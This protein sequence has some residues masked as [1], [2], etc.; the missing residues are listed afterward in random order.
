MSW[1][2]AT[3]Q[4][5]RDLMHPDA[6]YRDLDEEIAFHLELETRRQ[7]DAGCDPAVARARALARFGNPQLIS[8]AARSERGTQPLEGS[9]QDLRWAARSL[10]KSPGFTLLALFTLM[11]GI[12]ATTA[13]FAV[14]DTVL[15][16]PLPY[17]AA[18]RLVV[19]QEQAADHSTLYP[20]YPNFDD[21]RTQLRSFEHVA[22]VK[23]DVFR[24][25]TANGDVVRATALGVSRDFFETLGVQPAAGRVFTP[26]E[27]HIGGPRVLMVSYEFWQKYMGGAP[28]LGAIRLGGDSYQVVGVAPLGFQFMR[29]Y[30][31]FYPHEQGPGTIRNAHY[32]IVVGRL[33]PTA[34]LASG[35]AEATALSQRLAATFGNQTQAVDM[36]LTPFRDYFVGSYRTVIVL[37]LAGAALVLLVA[38]TNLIS[39]LLARGVMRGQEI[40]VRAALGASRGRLLR[41]LMAESLLLALAGGAMGSLLGLM[42]TAA[43]RVY[44]R[45]LLPRL[46]ELA[47]SGRVVAFTVAVAGVVAMVIGVYPALRLVGRDAAVELRGASRSGAVTVRGAVW[48]VLVGFEIALAVVL[49]AGATLLVRTLENVMSSD[50]GFPSRGIVTAAFSTGDSPMSRIAEVRAGLGALPGAS[51]VALASQFPFDWGNWSA[52]LLR[53]TDPPDHDWPAMAGYRVVTPDY[54]SVLEL[55]ITRGRPF[56]PLDRDGA[57]MVAVVSSG[58]VDRLWPGDNPIGKVFRSNQDPEH[59][60]TVVGVAAEAAIWTMPRG[61]QNE[62]YVPLAQHESW[63]HDIIAFVRTSRDPAAMSADVTQYLHR[64]A[65]DMP[66]RVGLLDDR[67]A[68]TAASRRF[69]MFAVVSFG[70]IALLLA[71]VG[72]YGVLAYSVSSRRFEIGVRMALG[73]TREMMLRQTL[74]RAAVM[75]SSGVIAGLLGAVVATRFLRSLLYGVTTLDPWAYLAG[76]SLLFVAALAGGFLPAR[77]AS[78]VD[79]LVAMR[80]E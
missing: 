52:P 75:A 37:V 67:I 54:F 21:W 6:A 1:L 59:L 3:R 12:G 17:P 40:A 23:T 15:I 77:R 35:R 68:A 43:V 32:L 20:S 69:A 18:D 30:D 41:Q 56:T 9:M 50:V 48:R 63:R 72:V 2:D 27:N 29:Q 79:P 4:R 53:P 38:C 26:D 42:L 5:L 45:G 47:L 22:S 49:I 64:S 36:K 19:M 33:A 70:G 65:R 8:E 16:E 78:R 57:P 25:T 58:I 71:A 31:V 13:A 74:A 55:P 80:G 34:S 11:L 7:I 24:V 10:R 61:T 60:L 73:A 44:G 28:R 46:D 66:A 14:F 39:A 76:A 62:V 51:S